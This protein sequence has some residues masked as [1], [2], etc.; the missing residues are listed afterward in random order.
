[1]KKIII[2]LLFLSS[3]TSSFASTSDMLKEGLL[4]HLSSA[5]V[6]LNCSPSVPAGQYF[7]ALQLQDIL[8][9]SDTKV[10]VNIYD[11]QP[12]IS[13]L[14]ENSYRDKKANEDK[15][16]MFSFEIKTSKDNKKIV[17]ISYYHEDVL[18]KRVN[19]GSIVQPVITTEK[20]IQETSEGICDNAN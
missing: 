1:M 10:A 19:Q 20:I 11:E 7:I 4:L 16:Q 5:L 17:G 12:V 15:E 18:I 3:S 13:V 8:E 6:K 9:K 2:G 14:Y